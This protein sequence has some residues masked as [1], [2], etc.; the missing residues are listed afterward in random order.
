M[1]SIQSILRMQRYR[2][3]AVVRFELRPEGVVYRE[4]EQ[5]KEC[6]DQ[7]T[8]PFGAAHPEWFIEPRLLRLG[9]GVTHEWTVGACERRIFVKRVVGMMP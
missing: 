9:G 7:V 8:I 1:T 4:S 6:E 5:C 2:T 3:G